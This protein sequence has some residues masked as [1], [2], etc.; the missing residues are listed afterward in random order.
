MRGPQPSGRRLYRAVDTRVKPVYP[1]GPTDR[2]VGPAHCVRLVRNRRRAGED[3]CVRAITLDDIC[4]SEI[5]KPR[6]L[7]CAAV[8]KQAG[9]VPVIAI[10]WRAWQVH[11]VH[12]TVCTVDL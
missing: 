9:I 12:A 6:P 8:R 4:D 3:E 2:S 7:S 5:W 10:E 1:A 11:G